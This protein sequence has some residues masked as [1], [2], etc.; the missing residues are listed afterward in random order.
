MQ[1]A[2][3]RILTSIMTQMFDSHQR[4]EAGPTLRL[5]F[6]PSRKQRTH[7]DLT[8]SSWHWEYYVLARDSKSRG[9]QPVGL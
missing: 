3:L 4:R 6:A 2:R 8:D 1:P 9:L 5:I 7:R